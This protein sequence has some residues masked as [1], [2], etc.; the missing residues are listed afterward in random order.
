[1]LDAEEAAVTA[2]CG[3]GP[4]GL[5]GQEHG[6][7]AVPAVIRPIRVG[8]RVRFAE[9]FAA[10]DR[11]RDGHSLGFQRFFPREPTAQLCH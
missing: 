5:G 11:P 2:A 6:W 10:S 3:G 9:R 4:L 7:A 8:L 1:V